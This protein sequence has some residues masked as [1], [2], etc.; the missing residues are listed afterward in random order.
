MSVERDAAVEA[1]LQD[2]TLW[3]L[4]RIYQSLDRVTGE[5]K[6]VAEKQKAAIVSSVRDMQHGNWGGVVNI[7]EREYHLLGMRMS[8]GDDIF[9]QGEGFYY[10]LSEFI[11]GHKMFSSQLERQSLIQINEMR[12]KLKNAYP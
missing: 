3:G 10:S 5:A 7:F 1:Q 2:L 11:I 12:E 9:K 8:G 4:G 6:W